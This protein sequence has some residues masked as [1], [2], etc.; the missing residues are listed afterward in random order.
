MWMAFSK[1]A[2]LWRRESTH[3]KLRTTLK[4]FVSK[5]RITKEKPQVGDNDLRFDYINSVPVPLSLSL[6]LRET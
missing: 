2:S 1:T 6:I 5:L 3:K 4:K